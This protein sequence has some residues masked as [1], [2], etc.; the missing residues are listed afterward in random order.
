MAG[1]P[2][3]GPS[4]DSLRSFVGYANSFKEIKAVLEYEARR[5]GAVSS[6]EEDQQVGFGRMP[7]RTWG[8]VWEGRA[9]GF[10][11]F[12]LSRTTTPGTSMDK[13]KRYLTKKTQEASMSSPLLASSQAVVMDEDEDLEQAMLNIS[14]SKMVKQSSA[15]L[16]SGASSSPRNK[17][18]AGRGLFAYQLLGPRHDSW[19]M[20]MP[21][22]WPCSMFMPRFWPCSM[23]MVFCLSKLQS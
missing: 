22:S 2:L 9:D 8:D 6:V 18:P 5:T 17:R 3:D 19:S 11:A 23:F 16:S 7:T 13:L 10:A 14:P 15:A 1:M 21:R 20:F 4:K 12:V